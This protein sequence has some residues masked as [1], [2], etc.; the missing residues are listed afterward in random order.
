MAIDQDPEELD[1]R[2]LASIANNPKHPLHTHAK[3]I[4]DRRK[5]AQKE[6]AEHMGEGAMKRMATNETEPKPEKKK[7]MEGEAK[8][9]EPKAEGA[10]AEESDEES[11]EDEMDPE[12]L[13][14]EI[15][16]ACRENN[17][18]RV[19]ELL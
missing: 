6:H 18:E 16:A 14:T 7:G 11:G 13:K 3:S 15:L 2:K 8:P 12:E 19:E 17:Q 1:N 5:N 10:P 9:E 4:I